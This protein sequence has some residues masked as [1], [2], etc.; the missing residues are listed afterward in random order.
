M[1]EPIEGGKRRKRRRGDTIP[2]AWVGTKDQFQWLEWF[3]KATLVMNVLDAV[4]TIYWISDHKAVEANPLLATLAH[5]YPLTFVLVKLTLV[6]LGS[7]LLWRL[8]KRPLAVIAIF[9]AFLGYY[10][11]L[12]YHLEALNPQLLSKV[13]GS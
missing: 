7:L 10:F 12:V 1:N 2:P 11:L 6:S 8:R 3:I 5:Q 4:F 9:A 13:L